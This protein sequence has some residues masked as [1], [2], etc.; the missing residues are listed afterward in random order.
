MLRLSAVTSWPS[1]FGRRPL[2]NFTISGTWIS[3]S[4]SACPWA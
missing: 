4:H 1:A 3:S 2:G